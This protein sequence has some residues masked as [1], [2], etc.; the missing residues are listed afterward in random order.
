MLP[1][2]DNLQ[3][4][5]QPSHIK[6]MSDG[7][8]LRRR[9]RDFKPDLRMPNL[10]GYLEQANDLSTAVTDTAPVH[11]S[12]GDAKSLET[13]QSDRVP[14]AQSTEVAETSMETDEKP[15]QSVE[16]G[17]ALSAALAADKEVTPGASKPGEQPGSATQASPTTMPLEK[18]QT[19]PS[20]DTIA[21][22]LESHELP[23]SS[24]APV[25]SPVAGISDLLA[26]E[27]SSSHQ[28]ISQGEPVSTSTKEESIDDR[29]DQPKQEAASPSLPVG[30]AAAP[31]PPFPLIAVPSPRRT[32]LRT[33]P[34]SL[35][36]LL[37]APT[38]TRPVEEEERLR[39][40]DG[41]ARDEML[42]PKAEDEV[43]Q[44]DGAKDESS[45]D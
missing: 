19:I 7:P 9:T 2:V 30:T 4:V 28:P 38:E 18:E 14:L 39:V 1:D 32:P 20:T 3:D 35:S 22:K 16:R 44:D 13:E 40:E 43:K 23:T 12:E 8:Q 27:E 10:F 26:K 24:T 37:N 21:P 25:V 5:S 45:A 11:P 6:I 15:V 34:S 41:E 36:S 31:T 17:Q 33:G 29:S 42:R